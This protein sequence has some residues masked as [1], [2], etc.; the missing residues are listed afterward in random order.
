MNLINELYRIGRS[1]INFSISYF[2]DDIWI[3]KLGED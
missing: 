1:E 2:Y 3:F